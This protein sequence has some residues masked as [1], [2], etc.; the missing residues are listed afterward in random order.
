MK[1]YTVRRYSFNE[2][3]GEAREKAV[4]EMRQLLSAADFSY[5]LEEYL[6]ECVDTAVGGSNEGLEVHF[7]LSYCQGD[8]VA[9]YGRLDRDEAPDLSWPEG[10]SYAQLTRNQWSN[11]YSHYNS[12]NV[13]VFNAEDEEVEVGYIEEQLRDLCRQLARDGYNFIEGVSSEEAAL[14]MLAEAGE[15]F[16]IDGTWSL[17][18]GIVSEVEL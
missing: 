18:A 11:H 8:G 3:Q 2:L 13:E 1:E 10:A 9:L 17:P 7:S 6:T 15:V 16:I 5:E 12:F 14:E 4:T